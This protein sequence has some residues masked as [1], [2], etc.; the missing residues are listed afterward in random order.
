MRPLRLAWPVAVVLAVAGCSSSTSGSGSHQAS[1]AGNG[2][3]A[4]ASTPATP[5]TSRGASAASSASASAPASSG[6]AGL[7]GCTGSQLSISGH[8]DEGGSAAGH[9]RAILLFTKTSGPTCTL[10]GYPG[11]DGIPPHPGPGV[12]QH[13]ARS[14]RGMMGGLPTGSDTMPTL[15]LHSGTVVSAIVEASSVPSGA[16]TD[17]TPF[18]H[19]A[20]TA[21]NT[22]VTVTVPVNSLPSCNPQVHPVV[23]GSTG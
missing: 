12:V 16:S 9:Q 15:V 22:T 2:S 20:V 18:Q 14:L 17:C 13:F 8:F 4:P 21:P 19:L 6:P 10:F 3:S 5:T 23:A 1:S 11:V 7:P